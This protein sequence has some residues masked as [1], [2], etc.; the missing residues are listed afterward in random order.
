MQI[1]IDA[2]V[3]HGCDL[4]KHRKTNP[5]GTWYWKTEERGNREKKRG[6]ALD[7]VGPKLTTS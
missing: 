5:K 2:K 6:G 4:N 7:I 1:Y 3:K